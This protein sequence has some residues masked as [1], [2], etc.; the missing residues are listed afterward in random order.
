MLDTVSWKLMREV[1]GVTS[2]A[3][4]VLTYSRGGEMLKATHG[5]AWWKLP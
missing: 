5:N 3:R 4:A 1:V 2:S